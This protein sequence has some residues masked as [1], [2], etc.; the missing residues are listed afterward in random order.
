LIYDNGIENTWI[1]GGGVGIWAWD[2][3][4]IVIQHNIAHH[5]RTGSYDGGGFDLDG[6]VSNSIM[7]Y[8]LSY[9]NDGSGY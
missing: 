7:H 3:N 9:E 8:N 2:S 1:R 4:D 5:N 6:G